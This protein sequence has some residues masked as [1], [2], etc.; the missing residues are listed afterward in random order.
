MIRV[1][2]REMVSVTLW[3]KFSVLAA[4]YY[5]KCMYF[6]KIDRLMDTGTKLFLAF[7]YKRS[8]EMYAAVCDTCRQIANQLRRDADVFNSG[9]A[10]GVTCDCLVRL[11]L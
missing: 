9:A 7:S 3:H 5:K 8:Q 4:K 11:V 2:E 1:A 10:S 6:W